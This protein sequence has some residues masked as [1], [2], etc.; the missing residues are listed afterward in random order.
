MKCSIS[1]EQ[2]VKLGRVTA[3]PIHV[4]KAEASKS[5]AEIDPC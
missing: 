5:V 3:G 1:N 4:Q 2:R